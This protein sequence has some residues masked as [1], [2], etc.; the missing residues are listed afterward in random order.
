MKRFLFSSTDGSNKTFINLIRAVIILLAILILMSGSTFVVSIAN[1]LSKAIAGVF[2]PL[3]LSFV[4]VYLLNPILLFL[5]SYH[6]GRT[7]SICLLFILILFIIGA[8]FN[9][10]IPPIQ[11][12]VTSLQK[13]YPIYKERIVQTIEQQENF[14]KTRFPVL[15]SIDISRSFSRYV[16]DNLYQNNQPDLLISSS[17]IIGSIFYTIILVPFITFFFLRDGIR[18]KKALIRMIPNRY[19]EMSLNIIYQINRQLGGFIRARLIEAFLIGAICYIGLVILGIKYTAVLAIIAGVTNLIPYIGPIIGAIP[20]LLIA[21]VDNGNWTTFLWVA[22]VYLVAQLADNLVIVPALFSKIV[23]MH[24]LTVVIVIIV[25]GQLG[26]IIG[27]ILAVPFYSI[28]KVTIRE[29][30]TGLTSLRI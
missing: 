27:M 7:F 11:K 24:P 10:V 28:I 5:E 20:A 4:L 26:G 19:F 29:I 15:R 13:R 30:H 14:L 25:G 16:Q 21:L 9:T 8:I 3:L 1:V 2:I 18:M 17:R 12:E 6:L 22:I 23:D